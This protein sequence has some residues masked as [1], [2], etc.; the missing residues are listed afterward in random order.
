MKTIFLLLTTVCMCACSNGV[1]LPSEKTDTP[2]KAAT[3]L[4]KTTQKGSA[5]SYLCQGG[6]EV[7][8]VRVVRKNKKAKTVQIINVTF[9]DITQRLSPVVSESGKKY[10]NIRWHW[11][12]K[13]RFS[14]LTNSQGQV[15]AEQC[16][17][18]S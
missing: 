15:L 8:V 6:K 16:V 12:E 13:D 1:L 17:P 10:S 18:Q 11:Y 9:N 7:K 14:M 5:V 2:I 3:S 4:D